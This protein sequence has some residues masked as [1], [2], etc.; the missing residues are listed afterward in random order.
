MGREQ[1]QKLSRLFCSFLAFMSILAVALANYSSQSPRKGKRPMS[2]VYLNHFFIIV[3]SETYRAIKASEF[4]QQQFAVFEERTTSS[5]NQTWSGLY[6][7][8]QSTYLEFMSPG[9]L[10]GQQ[11]GD[12]SIAFGVDL[13]GEHNVI[14]QTITD[15]SL[16]PLENTLFHR[17][18]GDRKIPWFYF[19]EPQ[20][21]TESPWFESW[22]MEYH[23]NFVPEWCPG[24]QPKSSNIRRESVLDC[25][26]ERILQGNPH[27][28]SVLRDV[29]GLSVALPPHDLK[30]FS[31]WLTAL[32]YTLTHRGNSMVFRGPEIEIEVSPA[33]SRR[34]GITQARLALNRPLPSTLKFGPR[35]SLRPV[36]KLHAVWDF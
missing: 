3:D 24:V 26:K 5:Q 6:Y 4:L 19:V 1:R 23:E 9:S 17:S 7:Y 18:S 25:Y 14:L 15:K 32:G 35:M 21:E 34:K 22:V 36:D 10:G 13:P 11:V 8:G 29:V 2:K 16:V 31:K 28:P 33:T 27:P 12:C 30:R 20:N